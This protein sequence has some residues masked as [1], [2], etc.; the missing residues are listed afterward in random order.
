MHT[1]AIFFHDVAKHCGLYTVNDV[2]AFSGDKMT[3]SENLYIILD[4][5]SA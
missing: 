3:I 4:E 1:G 5:I 2:V